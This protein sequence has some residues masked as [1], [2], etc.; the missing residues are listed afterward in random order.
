MAE[1]PEH[2]LPKKLERVLAS[3]AVK[4]RKDANELPLR[5]IVNSRYRV[6][7]DYSYDNWDGGQYGHA[8]YFDLPEALYHE[9]MDE[10]GPL[11]Q[12]LSQDLNKLC[13][14]PHE[15]IAEVFLE[16]EDGP[17]IADWRERSGVQM[18]RDSALVPATVQDV[19]R[20]WDEGVL[21]IFLSHKTEFKRETKELKDEFLRYGVASFVAHEDI[22]PT[23][24]WLDEIERA[25]ST[26]H[27]MV[28]LLTEKF[29]DS[30]WTDQEIGVAIG[31]GVPIVSVRLGK[32]PYGFIGKYQGMQGAGKSVKELAKTL[33]GLFLRSE[34]IKATA[35]E[36][37]VF[38]VE[39]AASWDHANT[40]AEFMPLLG[41]L[42]P[43]QVERL[44][45]AYNTN[46]EVSGGFGFNG[47]KPASYGPGL[48]FHLE[49][50]TGVKYENAGGEL[51]RAGS[52]AEDSGGGYDDSP[53]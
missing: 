15:H 51:V 17:E 8:V 4:Y 13:N 3:L 45:G 19:D 18:D 41:A 49:R 53:F 9:I 37:F 12:G 34:K 22:E 40:L 1:T 28:P 27:V 16:L 31:R 23:L 11:T 30:R 48:A 6:E 33:L 46:G 35:A 32:D 26:M 5:V 25:L 21:R 47:R 38:A 14:V 7:E 44:I 43:E 29:S 39:R 20:L 2:Q 24:E 52:G 50:I 10:M 42:T 36:A